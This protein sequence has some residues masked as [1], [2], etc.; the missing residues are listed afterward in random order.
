MIPSLL[1]ILTV[2]V[3]RVILAARQSRVLR[4]AP[5][6]AYARALVQQRL[7]A[8]L[9]QAFWALL[10]VVMAGWVVASASLD[11]RAASL[12][13]AVAIGWLWEVPAKAWKLFRT[14]ASHGRNRL[15]AS[16]FLREQGGRWLLFLAVAAP[17]SAFTIAIFDAA[18]GWAWLWIW[19]AGW[20]GASLLRWVQPR[21][22]TPLF[23]VVEPFPEGALKARL[24]AMLSRAGVSAEHLHLMRASARGAHANAQ[25]TGDA[26]SPR[27]VLMDTLV[28]RLS[29]DEIEAVVAHEL[30]HLQR[31][32]LRVQLLTLGTAWLLQLA[33]LMALTAALPNQ[34]LRYA[35]IWALFPTA[36]FLLQPWLNR[37]Y[38]RFEFEADAAAA[39]S[40]SA[41]GMAGALRTLTQQNANAPKS[42]RWYE[43]VY[44]THPGLAERLAA[45]GVAPLN[46]REAAS[47]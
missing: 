28:E 22:I 19:A 34:P 33:L 26:G 10:V 27:I 42:D 44:H 11:V 17:A 35:A 36:G 18:G 43:W 39:A 2:V 29:A 25:V 1:L 7:G 41:G 4:S 40:S 30:G 14:D 20:C 31:G 13:I 38:R 37:M 8:Q 15:A 46:G 24:S 45:L 47:R 6:A 23:D 32:H 16:A 5:A 12:F 21:Y 9:W 3:L